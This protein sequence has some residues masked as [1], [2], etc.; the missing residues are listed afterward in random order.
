MKN[1]LENYFRDGNILNH[2]RMFKLF[3]LPRS[4]N[5]YRIILYKFQSVSQ[6][7]HMGLHYTDEPVNDVSGNSGYFLLKSY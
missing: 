6:K 5:V 3:V 4:K 1:K 7:R 2:V